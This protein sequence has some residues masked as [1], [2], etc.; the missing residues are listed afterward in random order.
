MRKSVEA[1]L[2]RGHRKFYSAEKDGKE[3]IFGRA[4]DLGDVYCANGERVGGGC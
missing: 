3:R 4:E 1:L 2:I